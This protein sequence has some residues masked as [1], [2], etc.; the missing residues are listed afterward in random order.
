[1]TLNLV[2]QK[3]LQV[4]KGGQFM[5]IMEGIK[6]ILKNLKQ[7]NFGKKIYDNL[8]ANYGEYLNNTTPIKT[9]KLTPQK[10]PPNLSIKKPNQKKEKN[11]FTNSMTNSG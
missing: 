7:S 1:M 9:P 3:A 5:E 10:N 4:S 6:K 8:I 2:V 11:I